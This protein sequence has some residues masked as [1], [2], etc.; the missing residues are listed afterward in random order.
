M[1]WFQSSAAFFHLVLY[2]NQVSVGFNNTDFLRYLLPLN[3][4][5]KC[6]I[7]GN[8]VIVVIVGNGGIDGNLGNVGNVGNV[9][10]DGNVGN[11]GIFL[12]A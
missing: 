6:E 7:V 3:F 4:K 11:V 2:Y 10:I 12:L 5:G 8:I 1:I 9:G